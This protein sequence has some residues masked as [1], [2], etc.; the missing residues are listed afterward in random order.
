MFNPDASVYCV[1]AGRFI[2]QPLIHQCVLSLYW[3][4]SY[5]VTLR[6]YVQA[7][8]LST[9]C[10]L[11]STDKTEKGFAVVEHAVWAQRR[12][13]KEFARPSDESRPGF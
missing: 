11:S 9:R 5:E 13:M 7:L 6:V 1:N 4:V 2:H 3:R 12:G 8:L 10:L